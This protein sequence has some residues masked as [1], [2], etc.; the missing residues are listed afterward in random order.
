MARPAPGGLAGVMRPAAP[1]RERARA[2]AEALVKA[3][4][5]AFRFMAHPASPGR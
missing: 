4:V 5:T 2:A 3:L 1:D